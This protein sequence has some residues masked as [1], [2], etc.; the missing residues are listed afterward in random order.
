L[1]SVI[2]QFEPTKL[3]V[4]DHDPIGAGSRDDDGDG[5]FVSDEHLVTIGLDGDL[6]LL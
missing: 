1:L 5:D 6:R 4:F 2:E 3:G